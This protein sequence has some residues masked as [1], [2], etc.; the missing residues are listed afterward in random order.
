MDQHST[1][2]SERVHARTDAPYP[3]TDREEDSR[4]PDHRPARGAQTAPPSPLTAPPPARS[5]TRRSLSSPPTSSSL[6]SAS[7]VRP[8]VRLVWCRGARRVRRSTSASSAT[9]A[10]RAQPARRRGGMAPAALA[11]AP[12]GRCRG[13]RAPRAGRRAG[14]AGGRAQRTGKSIGTVR[15]SPW[16]APSGRK[17]HWMGTPH[18]VACLWTPLLLRLPTPAAAPRPTQ[19]ALPRRR[20][21]KRRHPSRAP[22]NARSCAEEAT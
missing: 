19:L 11:P 12:A 16:R 2:S 6:S 9:P 20:R 5:G 7:G 3:Q 17:H 15:T 10:T 22:I 4:Q 14:A 18:A 8:R 1:A 13:R 21:A